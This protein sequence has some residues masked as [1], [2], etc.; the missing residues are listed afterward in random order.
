[1]VH[2]LQLVQHSEDLFS[3]KVPVTSFKDVKTFH[4]CNIPSAEQLTYI[5]GPKS[6]IIL[7]K[8]N[9]MKIIGRRE[10]LAVT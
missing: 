8:E 9:Y 2:G 3:L 4:P 10:G 5:S 7:I 6:S 1:M